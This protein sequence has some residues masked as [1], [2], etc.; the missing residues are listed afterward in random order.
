[1]FKVQ[2]IDSELSHKIQ[3][4]SW[5]R[6]FL[7]PL[8]CCVLPVAPPLSFF[9]FTFWGGDR[10]TQP[11]AGE[12]GWRMS[13][14]QQVHFNTW[15]QIIEQIIHPI[16]LLF[17]TNSVRILDIFA[18]FNFKTLLQMFLK[19]FLGG[20]GWCVMWWLW[21]WQWCRWKGDEWGDK[22]G[23]SEEIS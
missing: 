6:Q 8:L 4:F 5:F 15:L 2:T 14:C 16:H 3:V 7:S 18:L 13:C 9:I 19:R 12:G 1:M 11:Q 22:K 20:L 23:M 17:Y 10:L 21:R